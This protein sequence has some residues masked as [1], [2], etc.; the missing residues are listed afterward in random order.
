MQEPIF[1]GDKRPKI[2]V[3]AGMECTLRIKAWSNADK[4]LAIMPLT[5]SQ[6]KIR[7]GRENSRR[8]TGFGTEMAKVERSKRPVLVQWVKNSPKIIND[9]ENFRP[10]LA[11]A[12]EAE[13]RWEKFWK[14]WLAL[15]LK[16]GPCH[17]QI[18]KIINDGRLPSSLLV[19]LLSTGH[20]TKIGWFGANYK[21]QQKQRGLLDS[22]LF[23][24]GSI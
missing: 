15:T 2:H 7:P 19:I 10:R 17:H 20:V 12:W 23:L 5:C 6:A 1:K 16:F 3:R 13:I 11:A 4:W 18:I 9:F 8:K 21:R 24:D 22:S 14:R